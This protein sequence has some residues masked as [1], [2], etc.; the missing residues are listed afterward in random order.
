M[1]DWNFVLLYF[2]F[3]DIGELRKIRIGHDGRGAG[4][5]WHLKEVVVDAPKLGRKWRFP[6]NRWLDKSEDDGKIERD[7]EPQQMSTEDYTPC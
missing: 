1:F 4:A 5:G 6:C 7:L 3:S 2:K